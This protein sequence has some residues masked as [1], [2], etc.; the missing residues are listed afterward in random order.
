[1]SIY[2]SVPLGDLSPAI[3]RQSDGTIRVRTKTKPTSVTL[4]HALAPNAR[5]FRLETLGKAYQSTAMELAANGEYVARGRSG[6]VL[7]RFDTAH[8]AIARVLKAAEATP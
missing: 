7:G 8:E 4:W 1:M 3:E 5:D 2:R 6:E